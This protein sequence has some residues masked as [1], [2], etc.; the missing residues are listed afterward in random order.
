MQSAAVLREQHAAYTAQ[1]TQAK[2]KHTGPSRWAKIG[3]ALAV[4]GEVAGA[5]TIQVSIQVACTDVYNKPAWTM[6][7]GDWQLLRS[8]AANG[9]WVYGRYVYVGQTNG[10]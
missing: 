9:Y 10:Q 8:C 3:H 4:A 5:V 1:K 7:A 2:P 6:T